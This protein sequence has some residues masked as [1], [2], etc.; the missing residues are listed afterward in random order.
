M[1]ATANAPLTR[2]GENLGAPQG[3]LSPNVE[4]APDLSRSVEMASPSILVKPAFESTTSWAK[5]SARHGSNPARKDQGAKPY[6]RRAEIFAP[7]RQGCIRPFAV[8]PLP[9]LQLRYRSSR[10][11]LL[12][13][14][15]NQQQHAD[16]DLRP[17]AIQRAVEI[18]QGLDQTE[19]QHSHQ[20]SGNKPNTAGKQGTADHD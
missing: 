12:Q 10:D 1:G 14:N 20:R 13:H 5:P 3:L 2:W 7:P 16:H 8:S 11:Q 19:N 15:K 17:P 4:P 6:P 18:D 9:P